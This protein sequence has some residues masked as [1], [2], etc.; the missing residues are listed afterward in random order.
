MPKTI[1]EL[2][3]KW[4]YRILKVLYGLFVIVCWGY[5]LTG[6][7][8]SFFLFTSDG[9]DMIES[10]I[11]RLFIVTLVIIVVPLLT[12]LVSKIPKLLFYYIVL[13]SIKPSN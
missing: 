8:T 4:W 6:I 1:S 3:T 5:A 13:G 7:I 2:N 12:V 11:L 10:F 9:R